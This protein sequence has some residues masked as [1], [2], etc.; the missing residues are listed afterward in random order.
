MPRGETKGQGV[1][2]SA[3][4]GWRTRR[5]HS[6]RKICSGVGAGRGI[7]RGPGVK[8]ALAAGFSSTA[9]RSTP[10]TPSTMQ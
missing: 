4:S 7:Q 3:S 2:Q 8:S 6:S 5:I 10:E 1:S 9:S